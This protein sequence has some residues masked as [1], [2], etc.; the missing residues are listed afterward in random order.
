MKLNFKD[1]LPHIVAIIVFIL[2]ATFYFLPQLSGEKVPQGDIQQFKGMASESTEYHKNGETILW[3]NSMFS[4]MPTFQITGPAKKNISKQFENLLQVFFKRPIGYFLCGMIAFYL[5]LLFCGVNSWIAMIG[6]FVF[7]FSTNNMVLF[8]AG[9]TSKVR[10]LMVSVLVLAG[11]IQVFRK[12]YILGSVAFLIGMAI[13]LYANHF[14]MTYYLGIVMG[15]YTIIKAIELIKKGEIAH[16]GKSIALLS[17]MTVIAIGSSASKIWTTYDYQKSTMRG[18]PIL[19]QETNPNSSSAVKGLAWEYAMRWSNGLSDVMAMYIPGVTGGG[20]GERI[21]KSSHTNKYL[22]RNNARPMELAPLYWGKLPFT[23]GPQYLG[24]ITIFLFILSLFIVKPTIRYWSIAAVLLTIAMSMGNNLPTFNQFLFDNLPLL[25]KFRSPSSITS[26][27]SIFV[28]FVAFLGLNQLLKEDYFTKNTKYL[29]SVILGVAGALSIICLLY[30]LVGPAV[31]DFTAAGDA[32]YA[33]NPGLADAF[34]K[35]RASLMRSDS[36]RTLIFTLLTAGALYAVLIGKL[37]KVAAI[38][39]VGILLLIDILGVDMRYLNHNTFEKKRSIERSLAPRPVDE[40]IA[41]DLDPH[42]RVHDI[43]ARQ[44]WYQTTTASLHHKSI[45][46]YHAAKLQRYDD[47]ISGYLMK[48]DQNVLNMLNTKYFITGE[49]GNEK[50]Q[51][52]PGAL[53]NAWFVNNVLVAN[54]ANEEFDNL[55]GLDSKQTAVVSSSFTLQSTNYSN[56]GSINLTSY[57]PDKMVYESNNSGDGLAVFSEVWYDGQGWTAYVDGKETPLIRANYLLRAIEIPAG[58]HTVEMV[59][60]PKSYYTGEIISLICSILILL[61]TIGGF[62][63]I[64][65][66][67]KD[68]AE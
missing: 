6:S 44:G 54:S 17:L 27:T 47:I 50:A 15:I 3:T 11:V 38:V 48:G 24:A 35:D 45:G 41:K 23:S 14:Q 19:V 67:S 39:I 18:K 7:A 68:S 9:H 36:I 30:A 42:Y 5:A 29:K 26:V 40:Q 51:R 61:T 16:L 13:S 53:G 10:V 58:K 25:N 2:V 21:S 32:R 1:L 63:L 8:E 33:Q 64:F 66:N 52:N 12:K 43:T 57:H 34:V 49:A 65:K 28:A 37:K 60:K 59:F 20:S 4:G 56:A 55:K 46:G 62:Y 31:S 22:R